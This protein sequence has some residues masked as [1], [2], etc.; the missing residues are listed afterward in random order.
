MGNDGD[1]FFVLFA[2]QRCIGRTG[3]TMSMKPLNSSKT[4]VLFVCKMSK[5]Q[6]KLFIF[7]VHP[8]SSGEFTKDVIHNH[9]S[10]RF[11]SNVETHSFID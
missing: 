4:T 10:N 7:E 6:E 8:N 11:Q 3:K 2:K 5:I 1:C 9:I